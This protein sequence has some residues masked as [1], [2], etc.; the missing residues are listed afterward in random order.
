MRWS[1]RVFPRNQLDQPPNE[2]DSGLYPAYLL[3][4]FLG[5]PDSMINV[6]EVRYFITSFVV[7]PDPVTAM[8]YLRKRDGTGDFGVGKTFRSGAWNFHRP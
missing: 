3:S 1:H 5:D 7:V 6:I 8:R 4:H 2:H